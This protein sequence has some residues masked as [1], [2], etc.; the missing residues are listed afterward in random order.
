VQVCL[1]GTWIHFPGRNKSVRTGCLKQALQQHEHTSRAKQHEE[2]HHYNRKALGEII[3]RDISNG[4]DTFV[5]SF[6]EVGYW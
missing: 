3:R 5:N 4:K 6:H 1:E 2:D